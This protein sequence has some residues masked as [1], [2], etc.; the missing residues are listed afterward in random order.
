MP[1]LR[2]LA[3]LLVS[4]A[5]SVAAT[6]GTVVAHPQPLADL[7][8]DEGRKRLYVVNTALSQVE[9]YSVA[10]N[11]PRLTNTIKTDSTPLSAAISRSGRSLY[12]ACYQ[13][14]SLDIIDLTSATFASRSV[15]LAA[16][17]EAV[18]VGFNEQILIST[19]GT[20]T[21]QDILITY[22]PTVDAAHALG[23]IV[24]AP[25]APAAPA[26]PPPNGV[27][28][29][30]AQARL[31]A[32][33]DGKT[34]IGVHNLANN[35]RTVFVYDVASA[36]VLR[37]R[38]VPVISP[39]LA[40]SADVSRFVSGP[41][42]FETSTLLVLA[43]QNATNAPY[44]FAAGSNFNTQ[45]SQGGAAF[46]QT[47]SGPVLFTSYNIVPVLNPS[48]RPNT[49]QLLANVPE[50]LL[51][52]LGIMLPENLSG[53]MVIS[54]DSSTVYALS[55]SG[56]IVLPIGGLSQFPVA[57][58][59]S[60]VAL[61][62]FD[63]CGVTAAQNSAIIPVRDAGGGRITPN[64]QI[65]TTT[66]TSATT[67]VTMR[68]Y[69]A[70][71]TAS[72]SSAASR[73]IGTS[74]PDQVL[75]QAPEAI[76]IVPNVRVYQND[77]NAE[78]RGAIIPVDIGATTT[79]LTD[80]V[81]D[82][83]RQRLYIANP[84]LNRIEVFDMQKQQFLAPIAVGQLPRS[85]AFGSDGNTLYVANSGGE[86]IS[87]VDLNQN[88]VTGRVLY[89]AIPFNA[90]FALITPQIIAS[91]LRGPQ[92]LMSDGTMWKI[93]GNTVAPRAL[94]TNIFGTARSIPGPQS[95]VGTPDGSYVM[96]L[97][98]NGNAY[99]YDST[100]D[101][102]VSGRQV[103]PTP[104]AGYYGPVAAGPGGQYYLA[105]DQILNQALTSIGSGAGTGPVSGGGLPTG[106]VSSRPVAAVAAAGAQS[107]A[108]FSMPPRA[109]STATV[110]DA[111]LIEIVD[112]ASLRTTA[113]SNALEGPLATAIG[114][115]RS[116][117]SGRTMVVDT[118]GTNAYVLTASGLSIVP[119]T[120]IPASNNPQVSGNGVVN[121]ANF[122][123]AVAPG[124]LVSVFG[125]SLAASSSAGSTPLPNILGG[126]CVTLNN[127]P[128]PIL[129]TSNGQINAQLP[130]TLAAGRY[131]LVVRSIGNEAA[132]NAA[133][134]TVA[135]YAPAVFI[136]SQGPAIFHKDG[137]RVNQQH[138]ASRDEPLTIYA[139]GLGV[140]TGGKVTA[141]SPS[142]SNP[143]AI[144]ATVQLYFGNPRIK[145]A[146][147]I[148]DWSGLFPG[149]IGVYQIN[150]RIPGA[151]VKGD[152]LPV[153]V[154][155]GGV[156][157]ATTGPTA[158]V[159]YV[160]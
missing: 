137:T 18:A 54:S 74:T 126:T 82:T 20:G 110:T 19:I 45:T 152:A 29:L 66:T 59:D 111:G 134:V 138:P 34:I 120:P 113:T 153:T 21:G 15:T 149:S 131:S 48:P 117:I 148:V 58:P 60:N 52:Q 47:A 1:V 90:A 147:V 116:N 31:Q 44:V 68:P 85:I 125:K 56:F 28:A 156:D 41:M 30:A 63:Q 142:P 151:H 72:F 118:A 35:T 135:K 33:T 32:S 144:T 139:T 13:S 122:T 7:V 96:V 16:S 78:S 57:L 95:M 39:V 98:G 26:L 87:V 105:D 80:M 107:F 102:F 94:N 4:L 6:F 108:R 64:A 10:S 83:A 76:N 73:T 36:T 157:S 77:R 159:V 160:N 112:V 136:D 119:L 97:A 40:V 92:V 109:S 133:N 43:Q 11:P 2:A 93:V 12:V 24:I 100:I 140:T 79:G 46:A 62:A 146:A 49:A 70:D 155:I 42:V 69:G 124:G 106:S 65:L 61:L 114:T 86:S 91:S 130:Q 103:I 101:D 99:L 158:A 3:L 115:A 81:Q 150:C 9:V 37:S 22:D 143:L 123:A 38:N 51:I 27:M 55:Q 141:G 154:R 121:T 129:A 132:S 84:G 67:R 8:L 53:K 17:P 50:N 145:E 75:I 23:S 5:P 71:V 89:P 14:S 25:P 88:A 127:T 104:I 128:L